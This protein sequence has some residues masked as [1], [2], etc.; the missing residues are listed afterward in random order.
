MPHNS[1]DRRQKKY[2]QVTY[3]PCLGDVTVVLSEY[4]NGRKDGQKIGLF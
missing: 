3:F 1:G 2:F 4:F